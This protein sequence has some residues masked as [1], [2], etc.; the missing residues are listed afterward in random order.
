MRIKR[1]INKNDQNNWIWITDTD[2]PTHF[3]EVYVDLSSKNNFKKSGKFIDYKNFDILSP[4]CGEKILGLGLNFKR[5][6]IDVS[7]EAFLRSKKSVSLKENS[8]KLEYNKNFWGEPE[9]GVM[10]Y[11]DNGKILVLGTCLINDLTCQGSDEYNH[12][13]VA[14]GAPSSLV[15]SDWFETNFKIKN[16]LIQGFHDGQLHR[17]GQLGEMIYSLDE[18]IFFLGKKYLI[19]SYDIILLGTPP[20]VNGRIY[21]KR[22]SKYKVLVEGLG[23]MVCTFS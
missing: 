13:I 6:G 9:I 16:Q 8:T 23:E 17:S 10:L 5:T 21:L 12:D 20:R 7:P 15:L 18:A 3:E 11:N 22:N 14:K 19:E 1:V 2:D 4:F